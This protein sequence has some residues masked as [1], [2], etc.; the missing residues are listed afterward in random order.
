VLL[1]DCDTELARFY[2]FVFSSAEA[3]NQRNWLVMESVIIHLSIHLSTCQ[4]HLKAD[5]YYMKNYIKCSQNFFLFLTFLV[6]IRGLRQ[7]KL[8]SSSSGSCHGSDVTW[9]EIGLICGSVCSCLH[10]D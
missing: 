5:H 4:F 9:Q 1:I 3:E 8:V 10:P 6:S 2:T 7:K